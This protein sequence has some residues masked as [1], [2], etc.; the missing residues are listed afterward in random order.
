[1]SIRRNLEHARRLHHRRRRREFLA[2]ND[3]NIYGGIVTN[4]G[5]ITVGGGGGLGGF[6]QLSVTNAQVLGPGLTVGNS[7]SNNSVTIQDGAPWLWNFG[8]GALTVGS[9]YGINA[10]TGNVFQVIGSTTG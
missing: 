8:G 6:N 7:S 2:N 10:D 4:V 9:G 5:L 1:M 3:V